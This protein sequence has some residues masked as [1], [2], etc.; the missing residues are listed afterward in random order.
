EASFRIDDVIDEYYM[1]VAQRVNV[2][3]SG[4]KALIQKLPESTKEVQRLICNLKV[5]QAAQEGPKLPDLV[6]LK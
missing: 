5:D 4:F 3:H 1:Y 2:N 6:T